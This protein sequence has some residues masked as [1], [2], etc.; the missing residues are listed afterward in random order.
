MR[1]GIAGLTPLIT[2]FGTEVAAT[3]SQCDV[4][5]SRQ[6]AHVLGP[7]LGILLN[8]AFR[9]KRTPPPTENFNY[10][11]GKKKKE[12]TSPPLQC[13]K[14]RMADVLLSGPVD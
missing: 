7:S 8:L 4:A 11:T 14:L 1:R 10:K 12:T 5:D 2:K 9:S 6:L 3:V 13:G